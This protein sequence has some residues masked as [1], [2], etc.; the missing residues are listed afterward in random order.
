MSNVYIVEDDEAVRRSLRLTLE[1]LGYHVDDY[2]NGE[3][4]L[5]MHS[6]PPQV[7]AALLLDVGLPGLDGLA[8]QNRLNAEGWRSPIV[9]ISGQAEIAMAVKA[10]HNGAFSFLEKPTLP[11]ELQAVLEKAFLEDRSRIDALEWRETVLNRVRNLS[12]REREVLEHTLQAKNTK[13]VAMEM[14]IG[15]KTVLRHKSNVLKKMKVRNELEL[16]SML[17]E[18]YPETATEDSNP[19]KDIA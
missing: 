13:Q 19:L 8:V 15:V 6:P 5:D 2:E 18:I 16:L 12:R 1:I 3:A 9:M 4:F 11:N 14:F 7:P 10:M 17:R